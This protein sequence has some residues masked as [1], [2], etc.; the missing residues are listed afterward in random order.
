M[1]LGMMIKID[2]KEIRGGR[3]LIMYH[4]VGNNFSTRYTAKTVSYDDDNNLIYET[5]DDIVESYELTMDDIRKDMESY[6][7]FYGHGE[8]KK[9]EDFFFVV[10]KPKRGIHWDFA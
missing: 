4:Q 2:R 6:T 3:T 10:F 1:Y 5:P 8:I 9:S 7:E